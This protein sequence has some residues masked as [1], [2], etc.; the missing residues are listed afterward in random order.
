MPPL[1]NRA[2]GHRDRA[3]GLVHRER[4][5][6][7]GRVARLLQ[8]V[9]DHPVGAQVVVDRVHLAEHRAHLRV[10]PRDQLVQISGHEDRVV[11]VRV[12]QRHVDVHRGG[13]V[14]RDHARPSLDGDHPH[15]QPI[16]PLPVEDRL[17]PH[18][19]PAGSRVHRERARR[20]HQLVVELAVLPLIPVA[21]YH[22]EHAEPVRQVLH[23]A[24]VVQVHLE[25]GQVVVQIEHLDLDPS[26]A[27]S[28]GIVHL[29][30]VDLQGE[31]VRGQVSLGVQVDG[32]LQVKGAVLRVQ[33][34]ETSLVPRRNVVADGRVYVAVAVGRLDRRGEVDSDEDRLLLFEWNRSEIDLGNV[35]GDWKLRSSK[36]QR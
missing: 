28:E 14:S 12:E 13:A 15:P 20:V 22:L 19:Q 34:E 24:D 27:R 16:P 11:V 10:A 17:V 6:P 33:V 7:R 4:R 32:T 3:R 18:G 26:H 2:L 5:R 21:G 35:T 9:P 25:L 30:G 8:P 23:D 36:L 31:R 29:G 1:E